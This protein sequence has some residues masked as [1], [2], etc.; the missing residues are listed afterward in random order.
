[1]LLTADEGGNDYVN[2]AREN[3]RALG[4]MVQALPREE[5]VKGCLGTGGTGGKSGYVNWYVQLLLEGAAQLDLRKDGF[6][7]QGRLVDLCE[8]RYTIADL[9]CG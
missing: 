3:A 8:S 9:L 5:D 4:Y 6:R 2:E 7:M 1:M